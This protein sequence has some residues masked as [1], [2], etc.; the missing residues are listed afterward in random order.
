MK[1]SFFSGLTQKQNLKADILP[2]FLMSFLFQ[3]SCQNKGKMISI[4]YGIGG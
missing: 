4:D 3:E 1:G 2:F